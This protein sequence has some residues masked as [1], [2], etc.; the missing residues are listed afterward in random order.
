MSGTSIGPYRIDEKLGQGGMGVVYKGFDTTLQRPVAI[1]TIQ[2]SHKE[3]AGK[4][5]EA[6]FM[7]EARAASRLQHP[8]IVTIYNFGVEGDTQY[9]AMEYVEGKTLRK[10]INDEP[11]P[12]E[13]IYDIGIQTAEALAAA[14]EANVVHRDMKADNIMVTSRGHVKILDFGL[15]KLKD[16]VLTAGEGESIFQTQA[17]VA[18]GTVTHMSPEQAMGRE[19]DGRSDVFSFGVVLYNMA[20]GQLPFSGPNPTVTIVRIVEHEPTPVRQLNPYIPERLEELIHRCLQ[21]NRINRPT[22]AEVVQALKD[23]RD[24]PKTADAV[25]TTPSHP[26]PAVAPGTPPVAPRPV[27]APQPNSAAPSAPAAV[28]AAPSAVPSA[29][30]IPPATAA[31]SAA[32]RA[33]PAAAPRRPLANR[34]YW[35]VRSV[36][37]G[38][39]VVFIAATALLVVYFAGSGEPAVRRLL[40]S[41]GIYTV[42]KSLAASRVTQFDQLLPIKTLSGTWDFGCLILAGLLLVL[43]AFFVAPLWSLEDRL[44]GR[45]NSR[46]R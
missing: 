14:H 20:T 2:A 35:V 1:K 10:I 11:I 23:L 39:S 34:A 24:A 44:R 15:A 7:R 43:R 30:T 31:P 40:N 27:A 8:A 13:Q 4:D 9:I 46:R 16:P 36:R 17:G 19:V 32:Q 38:V 37:L 29:A 6:R 33:A 21:K 12:L 45:R 3:S 5:S 42:V 26:A 25:A 28:M 41:W 22:S 18:L